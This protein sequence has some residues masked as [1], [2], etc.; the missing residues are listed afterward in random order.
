[1]NLL[2]PVGRV[3]FALIF[4]AA[5][6]RHF[7]QEGISHAADFGVPLAALLVP[8]SGLLAIFGA[9]SVAT[10]FKTKWGAWALVAFLVPITFTLHAFWN[11]TDAVQHHVQL[12]M[13]AKNISMIGSALLLAHFGAGPF[14]VD[15]G[16]P[17]ADSTKVPFTGLSVEPD[18]ARR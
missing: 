3:L 15:A 4:L 9:L 1:M 8:C 12:A 18:E 11:V 6:P 7:T 2:A 16:L 10:G 5:A 17:K 13:F 14:S